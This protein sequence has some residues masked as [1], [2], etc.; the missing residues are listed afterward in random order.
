[1][2]DK[3]FDMKLTP[4]VDGTAMILPLQHLIFYYCKDKESLKV[5]VAYWRKCQHTLHY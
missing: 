5:E 4:E 3:S 2:A 1:M